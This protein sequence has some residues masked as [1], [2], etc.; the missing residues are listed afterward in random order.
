MLFRSVGTGIP[1]NNPVDFP[2]S[3]GAAL[4][5]GSSYFSFDRCWYILFKT[6][7]ASGNGTVTLINEWLISGVDD[8]RHITATPATNWQ[9]SHWSIPNNVGKTKIIAFPSGTSDM[10]I[11]V[12]FTQIVRTVIL[13]TDG[14]GKVSLDGSVPASTISKNISQGSSSTLVAIPNENYAFTRWHSTDPNEYSSTENP[15]TYDPHADRV[16]HGEIVFNA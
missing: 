13:I 12:T 7:V 3:L 5:V 6:S 10:N 4:N 2:L 9:V 8:G 1:F 11:T 14:N 15:C 16:R